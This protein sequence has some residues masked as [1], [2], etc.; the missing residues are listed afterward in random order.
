MSSDAATLLARIPPAILQAAYFR[1]VFI[2]AQELKEA[3]EWDR[4]KEKEIKK[5]ERT[6]LLRQ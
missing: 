3:Q 6:L 4:K 1:R 5:N 2:R